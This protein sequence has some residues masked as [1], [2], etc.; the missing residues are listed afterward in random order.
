MRGGALGAK[1]VVIVLSLQDRNKAPVH[2]VGG[3]DPH[4]VESGG[5]SL[6][7][8]LDRLLSGD[9]VVTIRAI[10]KS[11]R[12]VEQTDGNRG[13]CPGRDAQASMRGV[14]MKLDDADLPIRNRSSA[15]LIRTFH[16][17]RRRGNAVVKKLVECKPH[18]EDRP[19][20][21]RMQR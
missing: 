16:P 1:V 18:P 12:Q 4:R 11:P 3:H 6:G 14:D 20:S 10:E 17:C 19:C 2:P 5:Q 7:W 9:V 21:C 15:I 13:R 8:N